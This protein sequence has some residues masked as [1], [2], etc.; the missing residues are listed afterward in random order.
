MKI[1]KNNK[2]PRFVEVYCLLGSLS[3]KFL[4]LVSREIEKVG[5]FRK[6]KRLAW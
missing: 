4:E 1:T 2:P 6:E 3:E 5:K